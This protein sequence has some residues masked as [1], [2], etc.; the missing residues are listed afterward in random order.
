MKTLEKCESFFSSKLASPCLA[1]FVVDDTDAVDEA[2]MPLSGANMREVNDHMKTV[3]RSS[4]RGTTFV[5]V[6]P[7]STKIRCPP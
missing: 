3:L 5:F 4:E 7:S 2:T 1:C 6:V